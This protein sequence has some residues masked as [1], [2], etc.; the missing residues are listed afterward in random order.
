MPWTIPNLVLHDKPVRLAT[1]RTHGRRHV[2]VNCGN[3]DCYHNA[4]LDV[5]AL[6]DNVTFGELQPRTLCTVCD[7]RTSNYGVLLVSRVI[8]GLTQGPF[9]GIG[10]VVA[11]KL[12]PDKLAGQA[13]GHRRI[14]Q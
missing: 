7:H 8:A 4:E 11:I 3:P 5:S 9:F 13:V 10:A 1:M 14:D 12:V 6:P 2:F